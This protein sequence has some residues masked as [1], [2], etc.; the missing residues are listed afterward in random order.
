MTEPNEERISDKDLI[1]FKEQLERASNMAETL[2][3][4]L[5]VRILLILW[6]YCEQSVDDLCKK[7]GKSWPTVTR[8]LNAMEE[9]GIMNIREVKAR[10]PKNKKLYSLKP[11]LI[12]MT[13]GDDKFVRK[14]P[15]KDTLYF[16]NKWLQ[17]DQK[18]FELMKNIF[19]DLI[20]YL[21]DLMRQ[22]KE[23]PSNSLELFDHYYDN[24]VHYYIESLDQEEFEFYFNKYQE[25]REELKIFRESRAQSKEKVKNE[26]IHAT[27]HGIAPIKKIQEARFNRFCD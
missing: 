17:S 24:R 11:N 5:R 6:S 22:L 2:Q 20:K 25:L 10:G 4:Y 9:A 15:P 13:R 12:A 18:T 26:R 19:D 3:P 23:V 1:K 8:H 27:F 14:I 16:L 7:L 21:G